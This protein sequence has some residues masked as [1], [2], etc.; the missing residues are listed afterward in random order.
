MSLDRIW[1]GWRSQYVNEASGRPPST[2][3]SVVVDSVE[4]AGLNDQKLTLLRRDKI[5]FVFQFFNLLPMLTAQENIELPPN[6]RARI[7]TSWGPM[8]AT[9]CH[10]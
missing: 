4:L 1:N 6:S 7:A 9:D 5:G 3:G 8:F 10:Y 2:A